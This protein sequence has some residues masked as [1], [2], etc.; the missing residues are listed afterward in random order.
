MVRNFPEIVAVEVA[1]SSYLHSAKMSDKIMETAPV[2]SQRHS[3]L[4]CESAF[5]LATRMSGPM[6]VVNHSR[7]VSHLEPITSMVLMSQT[8][9]GRSSAAIP[10]VEIAEAVSTYALGNQ[11][12]NLE[13][14]FHTLE[15]PNPT[16]YTISL[17][18]M[19]VRIKLRLRV[20]GRVRF[21]DH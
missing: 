12:N 18:H 1:S 5:A 6:P 20:T 7:D 10:D 15:S 9:G 3:T 13:T 8:R 4:P 14:I 2:T 17:I 21:K 16:F 11:E 19:I